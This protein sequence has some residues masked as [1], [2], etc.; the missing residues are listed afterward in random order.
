VHHAGVWGVWGA[1]IVGGDLSAALGAVVRARR[2]MG[3]R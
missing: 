1:L 3:L 2:M